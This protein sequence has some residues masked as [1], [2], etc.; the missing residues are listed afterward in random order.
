MLHRLAGER[1]D[2]AGCRAAALDREPVRVAVAR[3]PQAERGGPRVHCGHEPAERVAL[4][5]EPAADVLRERDR[6]VVARGKQESVE[7]VAHTH[8][9]ARPQ[10]RRRASLGACADRHPHHLGEE[11]G[12][13][14]HPL[15]H[16]QSR[17][18]FRDTRLLPLHVFVMAKEQLA[19]LSIDHRPRR[20]GDDRRPSGGVGRRECCQRRNHFRAA[21]HRPERPPGGGIDR[22]RLRQT[23]HLLKR[24]HAGRRRRPKLAIHAEPLP[25]RKPCVETSLQIFDQLAGRADGESPRLHRPP[26]GSGLLKGVEGGP[27]KLRNQVVSRP[28]RRLAVAVVFGEQAEGDR[29]GWA[30][31]HARIGPHTRHEPRLVGHLYAGRHVAARRAAV[32]AGQ[33]VVKHR[34]ARSLRHHAVSLQI[35]A[36][37]HSHQPHH[38]GRRRVAEAELP[39][40]LRVERRLPPVDGGVEP[41]AGQAQPVKHLVGGWQANAAD[42]DVGRRVVGR[43]HHHPDRVAKREDR[44]R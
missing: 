10:L 29:T 23:G 19:R 33:H 30:E 40:P 9:V 42:D 20:G 4:A 24:P 5:I 36:V 2:L 3:A 18:Q 8:L 13:G 37:D 44:P 38:V 1:G 39:T 17:H 35:A 6:G 16:E 43:G 22:S 15:Q 32:F 34:R 27:G 41:D 28:A 12:V 31:D 14:G 26:L 7:Q 25:L 11:V 21:D